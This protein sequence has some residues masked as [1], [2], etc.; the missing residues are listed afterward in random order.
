MNKKTVSTK[1]MI[2]HRDVFSFLFFF[3]LSFLYYNSSAAV[4][5]LFQTSDVTGKIV[6]SDGVPVP[7][8]NIIVED[9][10]IGAVSDFD[11]NYSIGVPE[12]NTTLVFSAVG[13]KTQKVDISGRAQIDITMASDLEQL[14]NVVVVGYG[15]QKRSDIT[16]SVASVDQ[17]RLEQLPNTNFAQALQGSIPGVTVLSPTGGA[18]Q[19]DTSILIRGRNSIKAGNGPL[20]V[21]DGIPYVGSISNIVPND[22]KSMEVLKDASASAIYGSRGANGVI[23]I[24]TKEGVKGKMTVTYDGFYG[25]QDFVDIADVMTG[26]EFYDFKQTREPG[27]ITDSEQKVYDN[28]AEVNWLDLA[29]RTGSRAQ[30]TLSVS[31]ASDKINYY[32][33]FNRLD[34]KGIAVGDDFE[35][36]S[37]RINVTADITDWLTL[38]TRTQLLY[39]DRSG[40]EA[41]LD[42]GRGAFWM[43]P[44]TTAFNDDGTYTIY[45]WPDDLFFENPLGDTKVKNTDET[46]EVISNN[47]LNIDFPFLEGLSYS[48]NTGIRY[49]QNV[50]ATYYDRQTT[51]NGFELNGES[52]TSNTTVK[53]YLVENILKYD[54]TFG[55]HDIDFTA[56]YSANQKLN[57]GRDLTARGFPGDLLTNYQNDVA[58]LL[59]PG[60]YYTKRSL[61]SSMARLYYGFDSRYLATFTVRRDG[62]SGFGANKKYGTFPSVSL[63]WIISNENFFSDNSAFNQLKLRASYG[64]NGNQA[65]DPYQTLSAYES[66]SYVDGGSTLPGYFPGDLGNADLGWE[67]SKSLNFGLD[68][69]LWKNRVSGNIDVYSTNTTDLLLDRAIS[70]VHGNTSITQNI[71]ETR[72]QGIE[73][74]INSNNITNSAFQWSTNANISYNENEIVDLYGDGND[75]VGNDWFIGQPINVIYGLG[76]DGI[77]QEEDVIGV[78]PQPDAKPGYVKVEDHDGDGELSTDKDRYII[79]QEDPKFNWGLANNL[80]YKGFSL[81]VFLQGIHGVTKVN[82]LISDNV[83]A[84]VRRNTT[85]LPWWT[86]ENRSNRYWKND[87]DANQYSVNKYENGGFVRLKDISLSYTF[88]S[89]L[90]N[91]IGLQNFKIYATGRNLATFTSFSGIDP[92]MAGDNNQRGIPIQKEYVFGVTFSL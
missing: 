56:L 65:V 29:T 41:D 57:Q 24:T 22:I 48:L 30:H 6:D 42:G 16:G 52:E 13:F 83:F 14:D 37:L 82:N 27:S 76:F 60:S 72:N 44:L 34:V 28:N 5:P 17:E 66:R 78:S 43:N 50:E 88:S 63:G 75:D 61:L 74:G 31:G 69:G 87:R 19:D 68:F 10:Q 35:R 59:R 7:G 18:E 26:R 77:F 21:L 84:E 54:R 92:E 32:S 2:R 71:G 38:G 53:S 91:K 36:S 33:S 73:L 64:K 62:Y 3:T 20:I 86:P 89:E 46:Y 79:G 47:F 49:Q 70:S 11:G 67:T 4:I 40:L 55:K 85:N 90:L 12:G 23:L 9:T 81:Y 39:A 58:E 8:I 15:T 25:T 80:S 45:P 51:R 1:N